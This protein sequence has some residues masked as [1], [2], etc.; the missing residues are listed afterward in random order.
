M[1]MPNNKVNKLLTNSGKSV[2]KNM[3]QAKKVN[4]KN[5]I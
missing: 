5:F 1:K 4:Q 3:N 2:T